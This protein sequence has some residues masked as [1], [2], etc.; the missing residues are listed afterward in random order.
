MLKK[1]PFLLLIIFFSCKAQDKVKGSRNVKTEQYSLNSFNSI[2]ISGEFEVGILRGNR[3]MIEIEADDNVHDLI[4]TDVID[5]VLYIKPIKELSRT[6]KQELRITFSDTL[7]SIVIADKV[8][9]ESLQDL[10]FGDFQLDTRN[11]AKAFMTFTSKKFNLIQNDNAEAELNITASEVEFQ[12]NQSAKVEALVN[13]PV[14]NVDIYEK[15]NARIDGDIQN[16]TIR[17]DQSSKFD[18][19]N[20]TSVKANVLAQGDSEVK[21]NA[22]DSVEI[23]AKGTSEVEIYNNPKVDLKELSDE[24]A[25][26]KKVFKKGI[27]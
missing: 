12:I 25:I 15:A 10:Y 6:K 3:S 24:A 9:L 19:E 22:T 1:L 27:F 26:A 20:L 21:V 23:V 4:Q 5:N 18:G 7:R 8:E 16:F 17:A 14:F 11:D 13:S 2:Q